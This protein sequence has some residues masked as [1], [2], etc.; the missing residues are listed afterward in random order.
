MKNKRENKD[1]SSSEVKVW[2]ADNHYG[3]KA[4]TG[5]LIVPANFRLLCALWKVTPEAV[6]ANFMHL[7]SFAPKEG[8]SRRERRLAKGYLMACRYGQKE[9]T[10]KE[11]KEMFAE[12]K[13][14]RLIQD[15]LEAEMLEVD[16]VSLRATDMKYKEFWFNKW[17]F[18]YNS[19]DKTST[20]HK[21]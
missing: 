15:S 11:I 9:Y 8:T 13:A 1:L 19:I 20:L 7:A 14:N 3:D 2:E 5:S 16:K 12:L 17:F 4:F 21:F 6:L 18:K 10:R